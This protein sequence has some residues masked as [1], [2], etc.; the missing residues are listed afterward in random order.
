[1]FIW[2]W[3]DGY[4]LWLRFLQTPFS[5]FSWSFCTVSAQHNTNVMQ[6]TRRAGALHKIAMISEGRSTFQTPIYIY[7][8]WIPRLFIST[9]AY[10]KYACFKRLGRLVMTLFWPSGQWPSRLLSSSTTSKP[11][12][13]GLSFIFPTYFR[14]PDRV[15]NKY[16][17]YNRI[18]RES[19]R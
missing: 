5:F 12:L 4:P 19:N 8:Y 15:I 18:L 13:Q 17:K 11:D 7:F 9:R 16:R 1:M 2:A 3:N 6:I 14:L 10:F